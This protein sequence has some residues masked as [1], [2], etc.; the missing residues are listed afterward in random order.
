[1]AL[2]KNYFINFPMVLVF[3]YGWEGNFTFYRNYRVNKCQFPFH[4][5]E[6][7]DK[8]NKTFSHWAIGTF[9]SII[10]WARTTISIIYEWKTVE[11]FFFFFGKIIFCR[12]LKLVRR[13]LSK[14]KNA[15]TFKFNT[16]NTFYRVLP[17]ITHSHPNYL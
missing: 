12:N 17:K 8:I 3:Q 4:S 16:K 15:P 1:M 13:K 10:C 2:G 14:F 7:F 5:I 6:K 11:L 9:I